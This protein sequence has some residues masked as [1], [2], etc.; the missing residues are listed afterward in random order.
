M[1]NKRSHKSNDFPSCRLYVK[2]NSACGIGPLYHGSNASRTLN[3]VYLLRVHTRNCSNVLALT[4]SA[5][6][7]PPFQLIATILDFIQSPILIGC[8]LVT[9]CFHTNVISIHC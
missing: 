2:G 4:F 3:N 9:S 5:L 7:S 1:K 8:N 6:Y